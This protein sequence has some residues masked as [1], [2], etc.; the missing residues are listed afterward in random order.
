[1]ERFWELLKESVIIQGLITLALISTT[2]YLVAAGKPVPSELW[3]A[4]GLVLGYFFGAK[5]QA[6]VIRLKSERS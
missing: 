2:C 1:M 3:A 4:N 6:A 5:Q